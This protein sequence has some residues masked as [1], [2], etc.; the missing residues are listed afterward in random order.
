[1]VWGV[2]SVLSVGAH[3]GGGLVRVR[4]AAGDPAAAGRGGGRGNGGHPLAWAL[5]RA[6]ALARGGAGVH[7]SVRITDYTM[8]LHARNIPLT[9]C[10]G[11]LGMACHMLSKP[12]TLAAR[13]ALLAHGQVVSRYLWF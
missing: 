8:P 5:H 6:G 4:R 12:S 13:T 1:M 3:N 7:F 11:A 10:G 2:S 9:C